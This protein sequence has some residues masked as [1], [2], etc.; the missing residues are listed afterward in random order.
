LTDLF[1]KKQAHTYLNIGLSSESNKLSKSSL[2]RP[3]SINSS[4]NTQT[5]TEVSSV[6]ILIFE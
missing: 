6:F 1:M 2:H 3:Q 4:I 5:V